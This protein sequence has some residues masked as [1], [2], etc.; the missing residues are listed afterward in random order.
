LIVASCF[1]ITRWASSIALLI[2]SAADF[3]LNSSRDRR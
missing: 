3:A 1:T 2:K